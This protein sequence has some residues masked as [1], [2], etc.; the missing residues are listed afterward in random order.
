M[1]EGVSATPPAIPRRR[2]RG[3]LALLLIGAGGAISAAIGLAQVDTN[4]TTAGLLVGGV[5]LP[6]AAMVTA[7]AR[8]HHRDRMAAGR[9][10]IFDVTSSDV[11]LIVEN[12]IVV[13]AGGA[14]LRLLGCGREALIGGDSRSVLPFVNPEDFERLV[15][16]G[17]TDRPKP[18]VAENVVLQLHDGRRPVV[19]LVVHQP[20]D[21]SLHGTL[22]R[23][24]DA[25]DR[26]HLLERLGN[27]G[28][29]DP[30][31]GL[32]NRERTLELG[33]AALHRAKRTGEHL[34]VLAIHLDGLS[35][36]T[37]AFGSHVSDEVVRVSAARLATALRSEDIRGR[38][39]DDVFIALAAGMAQDIGRSYAVDVADRVSESLSTPI[40]FDGHELQLRPW[41]G[42][43]HRARSSGNPEIEDL[44]AEAILG[45][46]E[47]R[48]A[49]SRWTAMDNNLS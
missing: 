5:G 26:H 41:I 32:A 33:A 48:R 10:T 11:I 45:M 37:D 13:Q 29:L 22:V 15:L 25:T 38:H 46:E 27:V 36:V 24:I 9:S 39:G 3:D 6:F 17:H 47:V 2:R 16:R 7:S 19:D 23:L 40:F 8:S 28:S 31:S 1:S 14:T 30:I 49:T 20:D 34:A 21:P 4:P 35:A 44:V 12:S 42:V 18:V 43:A